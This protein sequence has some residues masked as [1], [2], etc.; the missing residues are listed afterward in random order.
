MKRV[1]LKKI[2]KLN[3]TNCLLLPLQETK[4]LPYSLS[5]ADL[6]VVSLGDNAAKRSIPS[7]LFN[8]L[9]VGRP[10]LCLAGSDSDLAKFVIKEN[11]GK[12]FSFDQKEEIVSYIETIF[13]DKD[14]L[15]SLKLNSLRV[16]RKYTKENAKR[17]VFD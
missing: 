16:S 17:F 10:I 9:S 11:L 3:L 12:P 5:C 6:A 14:H 13:T 8:Y 1:I 15:D 7:K 2:G 4:D